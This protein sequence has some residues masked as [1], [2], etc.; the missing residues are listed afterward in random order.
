MPF[1]FR[2]LFVCLLL[3]H[4]APLF[5]ENI[6]LCIVLFKL[7]VSTRILSDISVNR[8]TL[9]KTSIPTHNSRLCIRIWNKKN[10]FLAL[11]FIHWKLA[12]MCG[13][14]ACQ[15]ETQ[16]SSWYVYF[17]RSSFSELTWSIS[18][19]ACRLFLW[20]FACRHQIG[21]LKFCWFF[22]WNF[23]AGLV[24][25]HSNHLQWQDSSKRGDNYTIFVNILSKYITG[26]SF[27]Y[28]HQVSEAMPLTF[29]KGR[30]FLSSSGE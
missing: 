5:S 1:S 12:R 4:Y 18:W 10:A 9:A 17:R 30:N 13:D 16:R 29:F 2:K 24:S 7:F 14:L 3:M 28:W 23:L 11:Q 27:W 8:C 20:K 22:L 21:I 6:F 15:K 25:R 19:S 26:P